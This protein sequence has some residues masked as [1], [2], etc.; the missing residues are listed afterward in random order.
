METSKANI[1]AC[2][3][4]VESSDRVTGKKGLYMLWSN[5][6]IQGRVAGINA[7]GGKMS[8]PGSIS[9]TTVNIYDK[10]AAAVGNL[11]GSF[12][13]GLVDV[14]HRKSHKG[15]LWLILKGDELTGAQA[16]GSVDI[17]GSLLKIFFNSNKKINSSFGRKSQMLELWSLRGLSKE[18][19]K[20][21]G[22]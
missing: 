9:I 7:A 17:I 16:I 1:F 10:G 8:Y 3:D 6:K 11:A 18:I 14:I 22:I 4:C 19:N 21:I 13:P 2:G 20:I 12:E 5:A 15:E